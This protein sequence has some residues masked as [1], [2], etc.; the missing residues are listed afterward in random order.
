MPTDLTGATFSGPDV[1]RA[2][3]VLTIAAV[4]FVAC[5]HRRFAPRRNEPLVRT[6]LAE[7]ELAGPDATNARTPFERVAL[8]DDFATFLTLPAYELI[9]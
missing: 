4:R 8:D 1:E 2:Q 3:E 5:P 6:M 7:V 9:D